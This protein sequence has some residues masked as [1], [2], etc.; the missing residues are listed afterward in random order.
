MC[1]DPDRL[2]NQIWREGKTLVNLLLNWGPEAQVINGGPK[3]P[4]WYWH[5]ACQM[6]RYNTASLCNYCLIGFKIIRDRP[7]HFGGGA[8]KN[9]PHHIEWFQDARKKSISLLGKQSADKPEWWGTAIHT[10]HRAA[11]LDRR[12]NWYSAFGWKEYPM[13]DY[14]WPKVAKR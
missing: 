6:W 1:L 11:L 8:G 12:I 10:T 2:G 9:Y 7:I 5:P 3:P 14:H 4:Q 13:T